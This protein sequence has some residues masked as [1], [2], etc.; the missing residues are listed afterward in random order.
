MSWPMVAIK[1]VSKVTT[2]K[3]PSKKVDSYFGGDIPFISPSEL[4]E[5]AFVKNAKQ[6][7][8]EL[9]A[10]QIKLVPKN[11]VLVCCI[12][13][14]GK[15]A[16]ADRE[17]GT[18]QQI[19]SVTFNEEK[20]FPKYGYYAL[21]RLKPVLEAMAPATTVAIVSK[22][23]FEELEI[24]LPPLAEQKRIA[25]ILDKADAIR[26][27][28]K[29]AIELA[30]EF[31]RSVF[32]D[33][34]GDPVTNPKGWEERKLIS[35]LSEVQSG[36][37]AKG[38][39]YPCTSNEFGVLKVSAVTS[40][41]FKEHENK[42]V[43]REKIPEGKRLLFPKRGDLLF[44]RANTRELVAAT[45]IV[46]RDHDNVFLPDKLWKI[47]LNESLLPE[48]LHM[49]IQQPRFKDKLTSQATGSSGSMLNISKS[50]FEQTKAIF[51]SITEQI[52]FKEIYWKVTK[53]LTLIE[54]SQAKSDDFFNSLSQK[55]FS[56][57][58]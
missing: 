52:K 19:N 45:C 26:Q 2:G 38:E 54:A 40:G 30:D 51:P 42:F 48:F 12:G 43:P 33:M 1:S 27:K 18:N 46:T 49:L 23:K 20:V 53:S 13:S 41:Y 11:S 44:S 36:W 3:T 7:L 8:S 50:K 58:L 17:L 39:S 31:L 47:K 37:S 10:Q 5:S 4:G 32:L 55:A 34:F 14:L 25:A 57:Q 24:P 56:G 21:A 15:L 6:T 16:I 9:G 29:Q 22:S 28:R 35:G